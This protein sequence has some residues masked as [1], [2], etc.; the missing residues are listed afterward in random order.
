MLLTNPPFS[1]GA[2]K[3]VVRT[4]S[5]YRCSVAMAH[6]LAAIELFRPRYAIGAIVPESL[7]Y[8]ELDE[9]ARQE[10]ARTWTLEEAVCVSQATFQ[11]TRAH[12]ALIVLRPQGGEVGNGGVGPMATAGGVAA[13]LVRGGLPVHE[14][15]SSAEEGIPFVHSTDLV[16]LVDGS[17][18]ARNVFPLERGCVVGPVILLPRVG[19]PSVEH[20]SPLEFEQPVQL[21]DCVI[22]LRFSSN[23]AAVRTAEVIRAEADSLIGL[24]KGTGARYVTVRRV[25]QWCLS[26]GIEPYRASGSTGTV[27]SV[28]E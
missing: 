21:S 28:G 25:E 16:A 6:I 13:D 14:A 2:R 3:G 26:I 1:M 27:L 18:R 19:V 11:G 7:L 20:V 4:G 22:G 15:L 23:D 10:L 8:S 5:A 9:A 17:Y 12:S 24:Y